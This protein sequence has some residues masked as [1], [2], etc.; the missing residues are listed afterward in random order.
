[1]FPSCLR[2]LGP[3]RWPCGE[4]GDQ[5]IVRRSRKAVRQMPERQVDHIAVMRVL[6]ARGLRQ[7][8]PEAMDELH[9]VL[10][11][12]GRV[13]SKIKDVCPAVRSDDTEAECPPRPV[14]HL[15]PGV[16]EPSGLFRRREH[17]GAAGGAGQTARPR[18]G[19]GAEPA[20]ADT[21][22]P[23]HRS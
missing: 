14:R 4:G 21:P 16:A 19:T 7:V 1:M 2:G 6:F 20:A 8:E 23:C 9:I 3:P 11:E 12:L 22:L 13:R 5:G 10:S 18:L 15:F 17:C